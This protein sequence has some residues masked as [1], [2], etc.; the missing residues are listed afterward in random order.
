[1]VDKEEG[2][3]SEEGELPEEEGEVGTLLL[4]LEE[5]PQGMLASWAAR[6]ALSA[7]PLMWLQCCHGMCR[8]FKLSQQQQ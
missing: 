2:E 8:K 7:C 3:V 6:T 1:M 4:L 5:G